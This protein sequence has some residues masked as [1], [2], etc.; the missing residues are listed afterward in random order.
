MSRI[1]A[2]G[3]CAAILWWGLQHAGPLSRDNP[4]ALGV[5]LLW[6]FFLGSVLQFLIGLVSLGKNGKR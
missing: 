1:F 3:M 5:A 6:F 4:A 2:S